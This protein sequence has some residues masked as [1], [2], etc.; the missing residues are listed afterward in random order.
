MSYDQCSAHGDCVVD[1][2]MQRVAVCVKIDTNKQSFSH[3]STSGKYRLN[4]SGTVYHGGFHN[5]T[6][7]AAFSGSRPGKILRL[8][9]NSFH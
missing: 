1:T 7:S 6:K 2:A 8:I 5:S 4:I 3:D 9:H